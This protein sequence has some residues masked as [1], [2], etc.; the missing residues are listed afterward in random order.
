MKFIYCGFIPLHIP[1]VPE[2]TD[3]MKAQIA[4]GTQDATEQ[5][6]QAIG[7]SAVSQ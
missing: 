5:I 7:P 3:K 6:Q 4:A 1:E 2:L